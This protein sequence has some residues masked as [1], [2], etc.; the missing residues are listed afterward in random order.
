MVRQSN[1][2]KIENFIA[3][4]DDGFR[5]YFD[6]LPELLDKITN[7]KPAL[8]YV[9][10]QLEAGQRVALYALLMR[11]YRT[12]SRLAWAAVDGINI[13]RSDYP[14]LF[15]RIT[16]KSLK[17]KLRDQI[18]PAEKVRDAIMHGRDETSAEIETAILGCLKYAKLL[19]DEFQIKAGFK[20][21]GKLRGVTGKKGKPQ[22]DERISEAVIKGLGF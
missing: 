11:E 4:Q 16:G 17:N 21:F 5:W 14:K 2:K 19:N 9:F 7:R 10:Q 15:E 1:R 8:A 13:N 12:N 3:A 6:L 22:L 20:P 18:A